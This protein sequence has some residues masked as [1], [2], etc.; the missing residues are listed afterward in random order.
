MRNANTPS[1]SSLRC[2]RYSIRYRWSR[3]PR[4]CSTPD[5]A[6]RRRPLNDED[7]AQRRCP[8]TLPDHA[9]LSRKSFA[10]AT[11]Y[12]W[13]FLRAAL[14]VCLLKSLTKSVAPNGGRNKYCIY[15]PCVFF[16]DQFVCLRFQVQLSPF[17]PNFNVARDAKCGLRGAAS[18]RYP[19]SVRNIYC[20]HRTEHARQYRA[21]LQH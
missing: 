13:L 11:L 15:L 19:L 21:H 2:A 9:L 1:S 20:I 17:P 6:Q 18:L 12:C 5:E 16:L 10:A 8:T 4:R 7:A 14:F 3:R